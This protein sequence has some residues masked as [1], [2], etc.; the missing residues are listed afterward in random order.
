MA[1]N[2]MHDLNTKGNLDPDGDRDIEQTMNIKPAYS[3]IETDT[4]L[5]I[6]IPS[7][8]T[9]R[10]I[11]RCQLLPNDSFNHSLPPIP[12]KSKSKYTKPIHSNMYNTINYISP[13]IVLIDEPSSDTSLNEKSYPS[14][15]SNTHTKSYKIPT[16]YASLSTKS[17]NFIDFDS[18]SNDSSHSDA[19]SHLSPRPLNTKREVLSIP[20][21]SNSTSNS[22]KSYKSHRKRK[23]KKKRKHRTQKVKSPIAIVVHDKN[24]GKKISPRPR[25]MTWSLNDEFCNEYAVK[26]KHGFVFINNNE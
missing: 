9:P 5:D 11:S 19:S 3:T 12:T 13:P 23:T 14:M 25:Q 18:K 15:P 16:K 17:F 2:I 22:D 10:I 26:S 7:A 1:M 8:L 20:D 6:N 4:N 21:Y 24:A